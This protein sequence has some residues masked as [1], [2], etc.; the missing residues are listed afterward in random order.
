MKCGRTPSA[1]NASFTV[2]DAGRIRRRTLLTVALSAVAGCNTKSSGVWRFF[3]DEEARTVEAI[4][5]QLIPSDGD[6][7]AKEAGVVN[8]IDLQLSKRFKKHRMAYRQGLA[9][10]DEASRKA[11]GKRF[12]ELTGDQQT[13]VLNAAEE[14]SKAFFSLILSHT[15]QGFYGDPR[16][17]GNRNMASWKMLGLGTP[18]VRGRQRYDAPGVV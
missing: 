12:V 8:Y 9:W 14:Q 3:S 2:P 1:C 6:P 11:F 17:G 10:V 13:Q 18:P 5:T 15:R 7:G 4:T 16:H